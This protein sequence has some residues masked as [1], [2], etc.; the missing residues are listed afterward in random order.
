MMTIELDPRDREP[1]LLWAA[2][3]CDGDRVADR[4]PRWQ[5]DVV[6][7]PAGVGH[8]PVAT[9]G[10]NTWA[11]RRNRLD[12]ARGGCSESKD[13]ERDGRNPDAIGHQLLP[14]GNDVLN[15][16]SRVALST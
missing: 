14:I 3:E 1:V 10:E 8:E 6:I 7:S 13:K 5:I 11:A 9:F 16:S 15:L 2:A 12:L 4:D